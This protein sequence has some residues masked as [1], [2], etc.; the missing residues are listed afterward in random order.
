[1]YIVKNISNTAQILYDKGKTYGL[2]PGEEAEMANP[3]VNS[4]VFKVT[5]ILESKK[6]RRAKEQLNIQEDK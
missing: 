4:Y 3:P 2:Q 6:S 1:M 5:N